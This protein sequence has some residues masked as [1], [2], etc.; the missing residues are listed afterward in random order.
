M[1][2]KFLAIKIGRD[3]TGGRPPR[4]VWKFHLQ[5]RRLEFIEPKIPTDKLMMIA[6]LHSV[7]ATGSHARRQI[8]VVTNNRACVTGRAEVLGRIKTETT[9]VADCASRSRAVSLRISGTNCLGRI[10][11]HEQ[12]KFTRYVHNR[13]HGA[14][15]SERVQRYDEANGQSLPGQPHAAGL[16]AIFLAERLEWCG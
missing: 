16:S 1:P 15:Q 9:D 11:H 13:V 14:A 2:R 7:L 3:T 5:D 6:R 4:E 8:F 10:L 12:V